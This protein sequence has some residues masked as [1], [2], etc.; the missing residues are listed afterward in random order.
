MKI[1]IVGNNN[2]I[3][4]K[5]TTT[6]IEFLF[7]ELYPNSA[8]RS[9]HRA[10]IHEFVVSYQDPKTLERIMGISDARDVT[11][12]ATHEETNLG[13]DFLIWIKPSLSRE[14]ALKTFCHEFVHVEQELTHNADE[15]DKA[16]S[17]PYDQNPYENEAFALENKLY[18]KYLA[19]HTIERVHSNWLRILFRILFGL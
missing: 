15:D 17:L 1:V 12:F 8:E 19:S 7:K 9:K 5:E 11:G 16:H 13:Y 18:E 10:R 6:L 2:N 14:E 3:S 4:R